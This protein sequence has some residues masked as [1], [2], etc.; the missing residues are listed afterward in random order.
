MLRAKGALAPGQEVVVALAPG[1]HTLESPL[2]LEAADSGTVLRAADPRSPV[3]PRISGGYRVPSAAWSPSATTPGVWEAAIPASAN[4]P[5]DTAALF[6]GEAR[7]LR[8]RTETMLWALPIDTSDLAAEVNHRGFRYNASQGQIPDSWDTSPGAVAQW[9][10]F[11]YH[12]WSNRYHSVSEVNRENSTILFGQPSVTAYNTLPQNKF[13]GLATRRWYI[14]NVAELPLAPG[15]GRWRFSPVEG[16]GADG[17]KLAALLQYAPVPGESLRTAEVVLPLL[18]QLISIDGASNIT[19]Q[20]VQWS[21]TKLTC[22]NTNST[23]NPLLPA[24]CDCL[25]PGAYVLGPSSALYVSNAPGLLVERSSITSTGGSAISINQSPNSVVRRL[26]ASEIG[27]TGVEIIGSSNT[28]VTD[29]KVVRFGQELA[30]GNGVEV[31][32][33]APSSASWNCSGGSPVPIGESLNVRVTHNELAW[34]RH[35]HAF[36]ADCK[37]D[38]CRGLDFGNN[39]IH[40]VGRTDETGLCDGGGIHVCLG[41]STGPA[42]MHHNWVHHV[43]AYQWGG[44]GIYCE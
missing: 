44:A 39:E 11:A 14:E 16:G 38:G 24:A 15:S 10:V 23:F 32:G 21:H 7:R 27:F 42:Y 41:G 33:C 36:N 17:K 26:N 25:S 19:I 12:S 29:S 20:D 40:D 5:S 31:W 30:S 35:N 4:V 3:P 1:A 37:F 28:T 13:G 8:V 43:K 34:G 9:R 18:E 2:R 6:V 22:P